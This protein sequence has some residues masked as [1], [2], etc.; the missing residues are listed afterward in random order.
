[1]DTNAKNAAARAL[2]KK[3]GYNEQ[4]VVPVFSM[5]L[6]DVQLWCLEKMFG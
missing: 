3:L 6:Y 5:D 4:A 1:V 2:Y